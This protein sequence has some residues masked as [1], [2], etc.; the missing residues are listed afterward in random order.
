[1]SQKVFECEDLLVD[2]A[3][4]LPDDTLFVF[5]HINKECHRVTPLHFHYT[6]YFATLKQFC[7]SKKM[8]TWAIEEGGC[9]HDLVHSDC[10][11]YSAGHGCLELLE[12]ALVRN[13]PCLLNESATIAAAKCGQL[14]VLKWFKES[15][16]YIE[17]SVLTMEAAAEGGH[18][19]VIQWLRSLEIPCEWDAEVCQ[20][21]VKGYHMNLLQWLRAQDPPCPWGLTTC[22]RAAA[23]GQLSVLRWLIMQEPPCPCDEN[24]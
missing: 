8:L 12:W 20:A 18:L 19:H 11:E 15:K 10:V 22:E 2:I 7:R 6:S 16:Y 3:Q 21:A 4:W 24:T 23:Q 14:H 17:M 13:P 1:M 9:P 5:R